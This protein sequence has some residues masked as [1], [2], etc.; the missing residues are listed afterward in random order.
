[1]VQGKKVKTRLK[2][3]AE[4]TGFSLMTVSLALNPRKAGSRISEE[5]RQ[6]I[7]EVARQMNYKPNMPARILSSGKS[8]VV[9]V[10]F[11]AN[12]DCF[13]SELQLRIDAALRRMGYTGFY[14]YWG[15]FDEFERSLEA[16]HQY[17][18][19]GILSGHDAK[20]DFPKVPVLC[21]GVQHDEFESVYPVEKEMIRCA[22]EYALK[23]GYTRLGFAGQDGAGKRG[24]AF[25]EILAEK[26][27]KESF[28]LM[29]EK[30]DPISGAVDKFISS[31]EGTQVMIFCNDQKA[32][33]WMAELQSRGIRIPEELRVIGINNVIACNNVTP[34]LTSV[35]IGLEKLGDLLMEHLIRRCSDPSLPR[36]DIL[37]PVKIV[38]RDSCPPLKTI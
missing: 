8:N 7:V 21:Y 26:G 18:V 30:E 14:T 22:V 15:D 25:K 31:G 28:F 9:G 2:D 37:L 20:A 19:C 16:M 24:E 23:Q 6:K 27:L 13:Y 33:E 32:M 29:L 12:F 38:E 5:T 11:N 17:N 1:M 10:M 34:R 4:A 3:I 36:K 35:D